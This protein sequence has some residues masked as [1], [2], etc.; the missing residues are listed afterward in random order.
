MKIRIDKRGL[1]RFAQKLIQISS[2]SG[3]EREIAQVVGKEMKRVRFDRVKVDP[4][5]NVLGV[6]KGKSSHFRLMLNG[7]IDHAEAGS[8]KS[9]HSGKIILRD[10]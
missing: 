5:A 6:L 4:L 1:I 3:Q 10:G 9:A 7:H 8:M 2:P